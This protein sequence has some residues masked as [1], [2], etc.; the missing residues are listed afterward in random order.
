MKIDKENKEN[1]YEKYSWRHA[2]ASI[3]SWK[4]WIC[5]AKIKSL[6]GNCLDGSD[7]GVRLD[8]YM[9]AVPVDGVGKAWKVEYCYIVE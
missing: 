3:K 8:T 5:R 9:F 7:V 1:K 2:K 4:A 6:F